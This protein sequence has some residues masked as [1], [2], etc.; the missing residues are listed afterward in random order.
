MKPALMTAALALLLAAAALPTRAADAPAPAP[1]PKPEELVVERTKVGEIPILR[2]SPKETKKRH[3]IIWITGFSGS[4][5]SVER[6]LRALANHGY[7]AMSFDP[8][9]HGDRRIE[10]QAELPLR[11]RGNIRKYFWPI[12]ARSAEEVPQL[13]DW[14]IK[15]LGVRKEVGIGG[16]SMG[17][18]ISVA[19]ASVDKRI[20]VVSAC[21]ATPDWMRPGS[22]EPPG[23]PD[24]A[25]Q[26][27]YDRRNPLTHLSLYRHHP[28]IAFQSGAD[29][30]QVPADGGQ[31]FIEALVKEGIYKGSDV[32]KLKVNL[33]PKTPHA[34]VPAMW[35]ASVAW[36]DKYLGK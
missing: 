17:G 7:V 21:V 26:V 24:D 8:Y 12:L 36:F 19:A 34:F 31:R 23:I 32:E 18:D 16:V 28:A 27:D 30:R 9:Q 11:V 2:I 13:I 33:V 29:D 15:E 25:A 3:L 35:E 5:D 1:A 14:A 20:K 6:E 22:F 4:R 10:P